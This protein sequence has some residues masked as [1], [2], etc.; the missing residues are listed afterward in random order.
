MNKH[1]WG[2]CIPCSTNLQTHP[3]LKY[4]GD[5]FVFLDQLLLIHWIIQ[6]CCWYPHNSWW[7]SGKCVVSVFHPCKIYLIVP[8][9]YV[10]SWSHFV[11]MCCFNTHTVV[12]CMIFMPCNGIPTN[13]NY[14]DVESM[15]IS[16]HL[17]RPPSGIS[18]WNQRHPSSGNPQFRPFG[19]DPS[20]DQQ[21]RFGRLDT[22]KK[23]ICSN[24]QKDRKA[25]HIYIYIYIHISL[26]YGYLT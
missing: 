26:P 25:I 20:M 21:S 6:S 9:Y 2:Y 22:P 14:C 16:P 13:N 5:E 18:V 11:S 15:N 12:L 1:I 24:P 4:S 3:H 23:S 8:I 10:S 7:H 19:Y 17:Q